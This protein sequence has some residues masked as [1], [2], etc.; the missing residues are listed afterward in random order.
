MGETG[1]FLSSEFNTGQGFSLFGRG[2][3]LEEDLN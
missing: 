1:F 3:G 2:V